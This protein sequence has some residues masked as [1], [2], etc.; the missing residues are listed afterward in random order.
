MFVNMK[1]II[2]LSLFILLISLYSRATHVVGGSIRVVEVRGLTVTFEFK[3][4]TH[5]G[6]IIE[7][8]SGTFDFGDG[9]SVSADFDVVK[10]ELSDDLGVNTFQLEHTYSAYGTYMASYGE[11]Y[12]NEGIINMD[13][14]VTSSFL[15]TLEIVLDPFLENSIPK[16][17]M[18]HLLIPHYEAGATYEQ[19]FRSFDEDGDLLVFNL[20]KPLAARSTPVN[21]YTFPPVEL[22]RSAGNFTLDLSEITLSQDHMDLLVAVSVSEYRE[23][24]GVTYRLS[25]QVL[26]FNLTLMEPGE[27]SPCQPSITFDDGFCVNSS[28]PFFTTVNPGDCGQGLLN[29]S[30][31]GYSLEAGEQ[32]LIRDS[33]ITNTVSISLTPNNLSS[34]SLGYGF[35]QLMSDDNKVT[36]SRA[37]VLTDNCE[38]FMNQ[39]ELLLVAPDYVKPTIYPNPNRG[40]LHVDNLD[41]GRIQIFSVD[42]KQILNHRVSNDV[43]SL[44]LTA[45]MNKGVYFVRLF[46]KN[47]QL[48]GTERL[49]IVE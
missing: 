24:N 38:T 37:I 1:K 30:M 49:V 14:S 46:N 23:I 10:E 5:S 12:R 45:S 22:D 21:N 25:K 19:A 47:D 18:D 42:G 32:A 3:G 41:N 2:F 29:L 31:P 28:A 26:D 15:T 39:K 34:S 43:L 36:T 44:D 11:D 33:V 6:S 13:N 35:V 17:E 9:S 20:V 48:V 8:G 16:I 7:L 40:I 27:V 4:Y